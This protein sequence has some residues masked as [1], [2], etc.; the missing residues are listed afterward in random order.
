MTAPLDKGSQEVLELIRQLGRP[1]I[2][3]LTPPEAREAS[4]RSRAVLQ[5]EPPAVAEVVAEVARLPKNARAAKVAA[6][7]PKKGVA[8]VAPLS[9][10]G[11]PA[12]P[13]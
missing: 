1:P 3:T 6:A 9:W 12:S 7:G 13:P 10:P 2:H 8:E 5:P 4:A 11:S